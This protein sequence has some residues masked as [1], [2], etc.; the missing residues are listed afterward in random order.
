[1]DWRKRLDRIIKERGLDMKAVSIKAGLEQSA[2]YNVINRRPNP[3]IDTVRAIAEALDMSLSELVE[4]SVTEAATPAS[5]PVVGQVAAGLWFED[6]DW[7][8]PKFQPVP[9]VPTRY[10]GVL[11]KAYRVVGDSMNERGYIDG[12]YVITVP[13]W[14]VRTNIQDGDAVVVERHEGGRTERTVKV[15]VVGPD[16]YRLEARSTNPRWANSAIEIP[17]GREH[18]ADDSVVEIIGLVIGT[19]RPE[20]D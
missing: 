1:M 8:A 10:R 13:Y 18:D 15:V 12:S 9:V 20:F 14:Q 6:G 2:V 5:V 17:R 11:Q 4:G 16:V 3:Q 7:D 19:Y